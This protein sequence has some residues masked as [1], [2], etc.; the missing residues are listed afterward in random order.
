MNP[1]ILCMNTLLN[2]GS[3]S[4]GSVASTASKAQIGA[5]R[6]TLKPR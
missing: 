2:I 3:T 4:D 5:N 1:T 6:M